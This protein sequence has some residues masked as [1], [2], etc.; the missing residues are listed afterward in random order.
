M[1]GFFSKI[2]YGILCSA[3]F[4]LQGNGHEAII[5]RIV[6]TGF[7]EGHDSKEING[8]GDANAVSVARVVGEKQLTPRQMDSIMLILN[9]SFGKV[10]IASDRDMWRNGCEYW[11]SVQCG[12]YV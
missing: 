3:A 1:G 6:I 7:I 12:S 5:E 9:A 8:L 10:T 11:Q 2:G 4:G